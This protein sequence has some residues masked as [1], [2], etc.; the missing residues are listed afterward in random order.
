M[1]PQQRTSR[2]TSSRAGFSL[3]EVTL[4]IGI[5]SFAVLSIVGTLSVGLT[6]IHDAKKDVTHAQIM[7]QVESTLLQTPFANMATYA[8]A[9]GAALY[10]DQ[11]GMQLANSSGAVYSVTLAT[12]PTAYPGVPS[13]LNAIVSPATDPSAYSVQITVSTIR[14]GTTTVLSSSSAVFIV[15]KS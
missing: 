11:T 10:F 2:D 7:A 3:V 6:T 9:S 8:S 15:P 1:N 13:T 4:V 12:V 5:V 14:P